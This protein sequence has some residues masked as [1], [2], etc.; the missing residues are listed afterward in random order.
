MI[1]VTLNKLI[2]TSVLSQKFGVTVNQVFQRAARHGTNARFRR[3]F[4]HMAVSFFGY[5]N[6]LG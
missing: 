6:L 2:K 1:K 5:P 4:G 3:I